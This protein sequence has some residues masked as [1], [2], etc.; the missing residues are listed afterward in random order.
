MYAYI[1]QL[2]LFILTG[3]Y[4]NPVPQDI[5]S[6]DEE[7]YNAKYLQKVCYIIIMQ[8]SLFSGNVVS[9]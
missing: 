2:I 6:D 9:L 7:E 4:S 3:V 1:Y 5:D 8:S